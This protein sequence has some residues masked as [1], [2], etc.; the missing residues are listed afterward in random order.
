MC[1]PRMFG[2]LFSLLSF[3]SDGLAFF[4]LYVFFHFWLVTVFLMLLCL[5][6]SFYVK[7][8][9]IRVNISIVSLM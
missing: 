6:F 7:I 3:L 8:L 9:N 1:L 4:S 2:F 5:Q